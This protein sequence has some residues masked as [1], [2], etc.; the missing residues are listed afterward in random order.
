MERPWEIRNGEPKCL[1]NLLRTNFRD[2]VGMKAKLQCFEKSKAYD[3]SEIIIIDESSR[4][5]L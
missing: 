1:P 5:K 3:G 4:N 2:T